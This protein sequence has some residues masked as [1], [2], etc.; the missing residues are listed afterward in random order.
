MCAQA[1]FQ[2]H[3]LAHKQQQGA[4]QAAALQAQQAASGATAQQASAGDAAPV[5]R[6]GFGEDIKPDTVQNH[7][8]FTRS[9]AEQPGSASAA[10]AVAGGMQPPQ[11]RQ[12]FAG[13]PD[14]PLQQQQRL[15]SVPPAQ[16]PRPLL[17]SPSLPSQ[18]QASH[19]QAMQMQMVMQARQAQAQAMMQQQQQQAGGRRLPAPQV[20][21]D[22]LCTLHCMRSI[23]RIALRTSLLASSSRTSSC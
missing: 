20:C 1:A 6:Q 13:S 10:A 3:L 9:G 2:Q 5:A 18:Q 15:T 19:Q 7:Q 11:S 14:V 21:G 12:G 17:Q 4:K 8:G 23:P 16:Q 22:I